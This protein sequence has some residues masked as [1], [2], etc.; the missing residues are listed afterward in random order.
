NYNNTRDLK[1]LFYMPSSE[2]D[3]EIVDLEKGVFKASEAT[4]EYTITVYSFINAFLENKFLQENSSYSG[5]A[6]NTRFFTNYLST[7]ANE[8]VSKTA[9]VNVTKAEVKSVTITNNLKLESNIDTYFRLTAKGSDSTHSLNL[10]IT[11]DDGNTD[12]ENLFGRVGI[13]IPNDP[14]F[15][16]SGGDLIKVSADGKITTVK[17]VDNET[18][19]SFYVLPKMGDGPENYN[20][21]LSSSEEN[22]SINLYVNFFNYS[23]DAGYT[24][25]YNDIEEKSF[26]FSTKPLDEKPLE[27]DSTTP[28]SMTIHYNNNLIIPDEY[29]LKNSSVKLGNNIYRE[30]K[31]FLVAD[32]STVDLSEI[33]LTKNNGVVY[34]RNYKGDAFNIGSLDG[35]NGYVLYELEQDKLTALKSY[36]GTVYLIAATIKTDVNGR[37]EMYDNDDNQKCYKLIALTAPKSITVNSTLNINDM[38]AQFVFDE[39]FDIDNNEVYIPALSNSGN[40]KKVLTFK[41]FMDTTSNTKAKDAAKIENAFGENSD[42]TLRL[43]I[44]DASGKKISDYLKLK[45]LKPIETGDVTKLQY[46]G[47]LQID[48]SLVGTNEDWQRGIAIYPYLVYVDDIGNTSSLKLT[49][50]MGEES[51]ETSSTDHFIIYTQV[52]EKLEGKYETEGYTGEIDI[53]MT[54]DRTTITWNTNDS[55]TLSTL[56]ELLNFTIFDQ[57]GS[58]IEVSDSSVSIYRY[59]FEEIPQ[60]GKDPILSLRTSTIAGFISTRGEKVTTTLRIVVEKLNKI[61]ETESEYKEVKG[62]S[63]QIV[64]SVNSEGV[65][66]LKQSTSKTIGVDTTFEDAPNIST[67]KVSKYTTSTGATEIN[68]A[69]LIQVYTA[70]QGQ[71]TET[72][73]TNGITYVVD[74]TSLTTATAKQDILKMIS[75]V[76][77]NSADTPTNV[78]SI[79]NWAGVNLSKIMVLNPFGE[80]TTI[81]IRVKHSLFVED[82]ILELTF[83]S[84]IRYKVNGS[85]PTFDVYYNQNADHM[86]KN[87]ALYSLFADEQYKLNDYAELSS[88]SGNYTYSWTTNVTDIS[89]LISSNSQTLVSLGRYAG[90]NEI[91]LEIKPVYTFTTV[92]NIVIYYGIKTEFT[93]KMRLNIY[94]NPNYVAVQKSNEDVENGHI[95]LTTMTL[96]SLS[97]YYSFFKYTDSVSKNG[98]KEKGLEATPLNNVLRFDN[99]ARNDNPA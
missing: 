51:G 64:V 6:L 23:S 55:L 42:E 68:L 82:I 17:T 52:A 4:G 56:N 8:C 43:E 61:S 22:A 1:K 26:V 65:S 2:N 76:A 47:E 72:Q 45:D 50:N 54:T 21:L 10:T 93:F 89:D 9:T 91:Y 92:T 81:R 14:Y 3:L 69:N 53:V 96:S 95:D 7:H 37:P 77:L 31:Y 44:R 85:T 97:D 38:T 34:N 25:L 40:Q 39:V 5:K 11:D 20:W 84:D 63:K 35:T 79:D 62:L 71:E 29:D 30:Y 48:E 57:K 59:R 80:D 83:L 28:I 24:K 58:D 87:G 13:K 70:T 94:I 66:S 12:L 36:S 16:I 67:A 98:Y 74:E 46:E 41:F 90:T 49:G 86:V 75:F 27:W 99:S 73:I 18:G 33:F 15:A 78:T 88:V 19:A 60:A 32:S